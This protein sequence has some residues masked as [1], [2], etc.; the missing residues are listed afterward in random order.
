LEDDHMRKLR[1]FLAMAGLVLFAQTSHAQGCYGGAGGSFNFQFSG[2][3][4][5]PSFPV[6]T[7]PP[8]FERFDFQF[9]QF[10][11]QQFCP[12]A[13]FAYEPAY[14]PPVVYGG[15]GYGGNGFNGGGS[16]SRQASLNVFGRPVV[17]FERRG[18]FNG[19]G[20]GLRYQGLYGR[21]PVY[22]G[23]GGGGG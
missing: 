23:G 11:P 2:Q 3:F 9:S 12:P 21:Q 1:G 14:R 6:Y 4:S 7:P 10:S 15:N 18:H 8:R 16:Y 5:A 13:A 22:R 17:G 19:Y 20:G